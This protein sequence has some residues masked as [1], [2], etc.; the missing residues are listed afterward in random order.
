MNLRKMIGT[1]RA[2]RAGTPPLESRLS[3]GVMSDFWLSDVIAERPLVLPTRLRRPGEDEGG[4][5]Q[6][7]R[8]GR[9]ASLN[10]RSAPSGDRR[11][12]RFA[13]LLG[14]EVSHL[15]GELFHAPA[16]EALV[17]DLVEHAQADRMP[18]LQHEA[19]LGQRVARALQ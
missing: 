3:H 6:P 13:K 1:F 15:G 19:A 18:A 7:A 12:L 8:A 9:S 5:L 10:S 16:G 17:R 11:E 14:E 2:F 4:A